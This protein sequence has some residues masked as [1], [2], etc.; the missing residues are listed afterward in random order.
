MSK[1][2]LIPKPDAEGGSGKGCS[3]WTSFLECPRAYQLDRRAER[4]SL[5]VINDG[6][7]P[8]GSSGG[9][10]AGYDSSVGSLVHKLLE[11]YY[12]NSQ[13]DYVLEFIDG[14]ENPA[15]EE[16]L[17]IFSA[18]RD[19]Y[20]PTELGE[21]IAAEQLFRSTNQDLF[22]VPEFTGKLDLIVK[23]DDEAAE[24]LMDT[25][26][27]LGFLDPGIYIVDHKTK[28]QKK[29][30]LRSEARWS[31]QFTAYQ[32]LYQERFPDLP[33]Q[34][35]IG[36]YIFRHKEPTPDRSYKSFWF[37]PPDKRRQ[38]WAKRILSKCYQMKQ[39]FGEDY[40]NPAWCFIY[41]GCDHHKER[42]G[43]CDGT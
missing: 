31:L 41:Y 14:P 24:I 15:W 29:K 22:G 8:V 19:L 34:G 4:S 25:R 2:I 26:P 37:P 30:T 1:R 35:L 42:G 9:Y 16:A 17:K 39:Q 28:K 13:E 11:I 7:A 18:Y 38:R 20:P 36:N 21:V 3:Y 12:T 27:W 23:I 5:P 43:P 10:P 33:L 6:P 40:A 32:M